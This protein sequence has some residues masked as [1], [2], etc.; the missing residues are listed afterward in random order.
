MKKTT[1]KIPWIVFI[2]KKLSDRIDDM[3]SKNGE[4]QSE[5]I[6]RLIEQSIGTDELHA[7]MKEYYNANNSC[8]KQRS[9]RSERNQC[10]H[11]T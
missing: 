4:G 2:S 7:R 11:I 10:R 9:N 3:L 8:N 5:Y 6:S 1:A